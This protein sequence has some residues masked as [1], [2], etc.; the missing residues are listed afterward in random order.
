MSNLYNK[1]FQYRSDQAL[2][3]KKSIIGQAWTL[4]T[5]LCSKAGRLGMPVM[6]YGRSKSIKEN[7]SFFGGENLVIGDEKCIAIAEHN[8]VKVE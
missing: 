4:R 7:C 8:G 6:G 5:N 1:D 2:Y 3:N